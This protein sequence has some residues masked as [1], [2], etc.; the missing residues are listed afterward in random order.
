[1][2]SLTVPCGCQHSLKPTQRRIPRKKLCVQTYVS[3]FSKTSQ[4]SN[5]SG[6]VDQVGP[7][8]GGKSKKRF[9]SGKEKWRAAVCHR[10][11]EQSGR[12]CH[13][14]RERKK[15]IPPNLRLKGA[16][17]PPTPC[18]F[19][20]RKKKKSR[21]PQKQLFQEKDH[22]NKANRGNLCSECNLPTMSPGNGNP[23]FPVW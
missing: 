12:N 1:M 16:L 21:K 4:N 9:R 23:S 20:L 15:K 13:S 11:E 7:G 17:R 10:R 3:G 22:V 8:G 2:L 14:K 18:G 6:R 19:C 5:W